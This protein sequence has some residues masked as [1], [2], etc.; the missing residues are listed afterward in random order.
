M[1]FSFEASGRDFSGV[2]ATVR[3]LVSQRL[4]IAFAPAQSM[5]SGLTRKRV[6]YRSVPAGT[7]SCHIG[8]SYNAVDLV[9]DAL[10][11]L[12]S[13]IFPS[14][15]E[16]VCFLSDRRMQIIWWA[17]LSDGN[18]RAQPVVEWPPA[19]SGVETGCHMDWADYLRDKAAKYRQL[20]KAAEDLSIKQELLDLAAV[21]E[22]AAD[23][24][25]DGMPGG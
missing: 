2:C 4:L 18:Q 6:R 15:L 7:A 11:S 25:E 22:E 16:R 17:R 8:R 1:R 13:Q 9:R 5:Y 19:S 21:C 3:A 23:N 10:P 20:A 14:L 24:I 12:R